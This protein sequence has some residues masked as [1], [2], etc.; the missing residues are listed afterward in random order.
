[1]ES[2]RNKKQ[3]WIHRRRVK[4]RIRLAD[5]NL[6]DGEMYANVERVGGEPGRLVDRL[7]NMSE[8]FIPVAVAGRH[9]LLNKATITMLEIDNGRFEIEDLDKPDAREISVLITFSERRS[10]SGT[11]FTCLPQT[12]RRTL[13][14]LNLSRCQFLALYCNGRAVLVNVDRIQHGSEL[15]DHC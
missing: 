14:Y 6:I 8:K 7:N 5:E 2:L 15:V 11:F 4:T 1:V 10:V 9:I 12:H 3:F 13:D